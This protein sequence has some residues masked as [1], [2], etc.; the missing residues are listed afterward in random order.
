MAGLDIAE[1][2]AQHALPV[3]FSMLVD[4][5]YNPLAEEQRAD[6]RKKVQDWLD[7]ASAAAENKP[8]PK[9]DPDTWG[10]LP[11]HQEGLNLAMMLAGE[12]TGGS[13]D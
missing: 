10:L 8:S 9:Y 7:D 1:M 4:E 2:P 12:A 13:D 6:G 11:E 5:S 3:I